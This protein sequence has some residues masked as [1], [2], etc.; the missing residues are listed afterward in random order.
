MFVLEV[1]SLDGAD[2]GRVFVQGDLSDC[3]EQV[4]LLC[5]LPQVGQVTGTSIDVLPIGCIAE[6]MRTLDRLLL[7]CGGVYEPC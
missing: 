1:F 4:D 5:R 2:L 7:E 6:S 3:Q